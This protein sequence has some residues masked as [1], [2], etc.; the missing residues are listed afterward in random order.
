MKVENQSDKIWLG[1]KG[2]EL[3]DGNKRNIWSCYKSQRGNGK[4]EK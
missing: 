4:E 1:M 3:D 2:T